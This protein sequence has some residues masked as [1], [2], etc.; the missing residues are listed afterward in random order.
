MC[1]PTLHVFDSQPTIFSVHDTE[2][3]DTYWIEWNQ[4]WAVH[5]RMA[6]RNA[7]NTSCRVITPI[8]LYRFAMAPEGIGIRASVFEACY[9]FPSI[10]LVS[11]SSPRAYL[12]STSHPLE[13]IAVDIQQERTDGASSLSC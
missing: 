12:Q 4:T 9:G 1:P 13:T 7:V 10:K 5:N 8:G 3:T 6:G 11:I 2:W